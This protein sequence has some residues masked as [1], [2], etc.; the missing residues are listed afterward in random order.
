M[1]TLENSRGNVVNQS[2]PKLNLQL[3]DVSKQE[4]CE[5]RII[6]YNIHIWKREFAFFK[7]EYILIY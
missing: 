7:Y 6:S 2:M 5:L 1:R 3:S 4:L